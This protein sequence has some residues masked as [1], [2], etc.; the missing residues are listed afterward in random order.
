MIIGVSRLAA[1]KGSIHH[2]Q[3]ETCSFI[4]A[5]AF[6][7]IPSLRGKF[8]MN[9]SRSED[10]FSPIDVVDQAE[11]IARRIDRAACKINE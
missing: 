9:F 10:H 2:Q 6:E 4:P 5:D 8:W 7:L 11:H 1:I 3:S